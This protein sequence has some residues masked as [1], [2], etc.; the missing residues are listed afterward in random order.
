MVAAV[1]NYLLE[2]E[3]GTR[4]ELARAMGRE[5]G[6][7]GSVITRMHSPG[8]VLPKRISIIDWAY[9]DGE[10]GRR[11]P[12]AVYALGDLPDAKKPRRATDC[13]N[14]RNFYRRRKCRVNSIF[15]LG[16]KKFI[17]T[18]MIIKGSE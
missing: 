9:D 8:K 14:T 7:V 4:A 6:Q 17:N 2:F 10:N 12:R 15:A 11:Y 1:T 3:S 18:S 16:Q 13:E 5:S